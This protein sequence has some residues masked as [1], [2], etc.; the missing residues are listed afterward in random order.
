MS[1]WGNHPWKKVGFQEAPNVQFGPFLVK[2]PREEKNGWVKFL[3][4]KNKFII[5]FFSL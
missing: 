5:S 3:G 2:L 4:R 1:T